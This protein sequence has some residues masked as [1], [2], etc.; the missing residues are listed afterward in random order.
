MLYKVTLEVSS[1][2]H[3][4]ETLKSRRNCRSRKESSEGPPHNHSSLDV[5]W[6]TVIHRLDQ[7]AG[8]QPRSPWAAASARLCWLQV[9]DL[10]ASQSGA[11]PHGETKIP[12]VHEA[13]GPQ[14]SDLPER[15]LGWGGAHSATSTPRSIQFSD[16][17]SDTQ[18]EP[19]LQVSFPV[20]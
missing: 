20:L 6:G 7:G 16:D 10:S 17:A 18:K 5:L 19:H 4:I 8:G 13:L 2:N 12:S 1:S 15:S 14:C 9:W 3:Q 11:E